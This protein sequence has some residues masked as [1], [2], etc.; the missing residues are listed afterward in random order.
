M[1]QGESGANTLPADDEGKLNQL[2]TV[3]G[4][5]VLA[6]SSMHFICSST[7]DSSLQREVKGFHRRFNSIKESTIKCLEKCRITVVIVVYLLTSVLGVGEHRK[8][9]EDKQKK[10]RKSDDHWE[11]FGQLNLYWNYLSFDLLDKLIDELVEKNSEFEEIKK[12]ME[13][14]KEGMERFRESTTLLLFCQVERHEDADPPPGFRK[15]VTEHQWPETI[16]LKDVEEFRRRFL[17]TFGLP[18]CAMMV[19]RIQR[20]CFEVTW[21]GALPISVGVL[22]RE[23]K[24]TIEVF[25]EFRVISVEIDG[26]CVYQHLLQPVS[27][28]KKQNSNLNFCHAASGCGQ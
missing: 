14:Y 1:P 22:L 3:T 13:E 12:E 24:G 6:F 23:S 20:K 8:F 26:D 19:Y 7:T 4:V 9:L 25:R 17:Y 16:T 18:Q 21:F 2:S 11:L 5:V 28:S 15:M 27:H 10:L